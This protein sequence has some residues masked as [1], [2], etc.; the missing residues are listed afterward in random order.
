MR[1]GIMTNS[2]PEKLSIDQLIAHLARIENDGFDHAWLIHLPYS[3]F[4]AL[5]AIALAGRHTQRIMFGTSVVPIYA[6]H[7]LMLAQHALTAQAATNGRLILG[8]GLSHQVV[9]ENA[10][11][12][13]Y[14]KPARRMREYLSIVRALIDTGRVE[15]KGEVYNVNAELNVIGSSSC[16]IVIAALAPQ[17]LRLAGEMADG[18]VTW[19]AGRRTLETHIIPRITAAAKECGRPQPRIVVGLPVAVADDPRKARDDATAMLQ[20]YDALPNYRRLLDMEGAAHA[21]D[22]LITG[23]EAEVEKQLRELAAIGVT[24]FIASIFPADEDAAKSTK[25]TW[26]LLRNLVGQL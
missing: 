22:T 1:L 4:D 7:P 20:R 23:N 2:R 8:L 15:F 13:S 10:M 3:G 26:T 16:P 12:L 11:G 6:Y 19:L 5:T 18:T 25:R 21:G 14:E 17:M 24:D 9:V